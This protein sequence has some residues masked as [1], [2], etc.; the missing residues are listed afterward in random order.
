MLI[1]LVLL[2]IL[3]YYS[4]LL[5]LTTNRIGAFDDAF[6]S[7]I[8][9]VLHYPA[10]KD[11]QRQEIWRSFFA[12]LQKERGDAIR[13][14][15]ETKEYAMKSSDVQ[16]LNWNG[17]EIRNGKL[18][19]GASGICRKELT[20]S[21]IAFQ[22]AIALAEFDAEEEPDRKEDGLILVEEEHLSRVVRMSRSFQ[23]Y[24]ESLHG[25][26]EAKRAERQRAYKA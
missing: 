11:S 12:K 21:P 6:V 1:S 14:P 18:P 5:V 24:L 8:H 10:L 9:V 19:Y 4:G 2:R 16:G 17:R 22:T 23:D 20:G 7:R 15:I 25:G 3:E 26:S 13:I